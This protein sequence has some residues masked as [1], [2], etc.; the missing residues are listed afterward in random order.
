MDFS[1]IKE[2][3]AK[4]AVRLNLKQNLCFVRGEGAKLFDTSGKSYLDFSG[5]GENC[6]GYGDEKLTEAVIDR[7]KRL[8]SPPAEYYCDNYGA[9]LAKLL[10]NTGFTKACFSGSGLEANLTA[11][12]LI[13][14]HLK[15]SGD[16]RGRVVVT[17]LREDETGVKSEAGVAAGAGYKRVLVRINDFAALKKALTPSTAAFIVQPVLSDSGVII[18]DYDYLV[19][20]YALCKSMGII[21]FCDETRIGAGITGKKFAFEHYGIQP[22]IVTLSR[23]LA[24]GLPIGAVLTRD[25]IAAG[26]KPS[27]HGFD[28]L[29][30]W[31]ISGTEGSNAL[32]CAA[33]DIVL[34]RLENGLAEEATQK[35]EYLLSRLYRL[36]KY[37]F[38]L[39]I[40]GR[41]LLA[42]IELS[43][44]IMAAKVA[45]QMEKLGYLLDYTDGNILRFSPPFIVSKSEIDEVTNALSDLFASTNI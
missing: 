28:V 15:E 25:A 36:T 35:G 34:D 20:A 39:N 32:S 9:A 40:R 26:I 30:T 37:N 3:E 13:R 45:G 7:A 21:L 23:G 43:G 44:R 22:D 17:S 5:G 19:N 42:A 16:G 14:N 24:G 12:A 33:A 41:G 6:L 38:V 2:L 10:N 31:G 27:R 1:S 18:A 8:A 11:I 29:G 4:H